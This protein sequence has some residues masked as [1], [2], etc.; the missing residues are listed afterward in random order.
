ME[1]MKEFYKGN[2]S[3]TKVLVSSGA[4]PKMVTDFYIENTG[5]MKSIDINVDDIRVYND[6]VDSGD[7][8]NIKSRLYVDKSSNVKITTRTLSDAKK[9]E[10]I[11]SKYPYDKGV[12]AYFYFGD[13]AVLRYLSTGELA[14]FITTSGTLFQVPEFKNTALLADI[15]RDPDFLQAH[16]IGKYLLI[17]TKNKITSTSKFYTALIDTTDNS[18]I[19]SLKGIKDSA[20]NLENISRDI[21]T[22]WFSQRIDKDNFILAYNNSTSN[23][24]GRFTPY[25]G[26]VS[27]SVVFLINSKLNKIER[28]SNDGSAGGSTTD[29]V[30]EKYLYIPSINSIIYGSNILASGGGRN[31]S[32]INLTTMNIT[33][34][35][36]FNTTSQ[37]TLINTIVGVSADSRYLYM[38]NYNNVFGIFD[39]QNRSVD[40]LD[41]YNV[42]NKVIYKGRIFNN[43]GSKFRTIDGKSIYESTDTSIM[44][45]DQLYHSCGI[46]VKNE[47]KLINH[48][49]I[50]DLDSCKFDTKVNEEGYFKMAVDQPYRID[51]SS[52]PLE[53]DKNLTE[54]IVVNK[55][56]STYCTFKFKGEL[57]LSDI[58]VNL[59]TAIIKGADG[60][61]YILYAVNYY[62]FNIKKVMLDSSSNV[63]VSVDY[64]KNVA[65]STSYI[66][67]SSPVFSTNKATSYSST[68]GGLIYANTTTGTFLFKGNNSSGYPTVYCVCIEGNAVYNDYV[69]TTGYL[70]T[71]ST[72]YTNRLGV[73]ERNNEVFLVEMN[74]TGY[75]CTIH[76]FHPKTPNKVTS[77]ATT[78]LA[79]YKSYY[80][81][82]STPNVLSYI[83]L[84]E[85]G[86]VLHPNHTN[87]NKWIV[88]YNFTSYS[89]V[90]SVSNRTEDDLFEDNTAQNDLVSG[91]VFDKTKYSFIDNSLKVKVDG[92]EFI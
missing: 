28:L 85:D 13:G 38:V 39:T 64:A 57:T 18:M 92:I 31:F 10:V 69:G 21:S 1:K 2:V 74:T 5:D 24:S 77:I 80:V 51:A 17:N 9:V 58:P 60:S 8:I 62:T 42:G 30:A 75:Y 82:A 49:S 79:N 55:Q 89:H 83:L 70:Y 25:S 43:Q 61:Y 3:D 6:T 41:S 27:A 16:V 54:D 45:D 26:I 84:K 20:L 65:F 78:S 29:T 50:L 87:T 37:Q 12:D 33:T 14:V 47:N 15:Q 56:S 4:N 88:P 40:T 52:F 36:T 91:E 19:R 76:R 67:S 23:Q 35:D 44:S 90:K 86:F 7:T 66:H 59:Y 71:Y 53:E 34:I 22:D 73:F 48:N 11:N 46:Y 72:T 63:L 68:Y 32:I 81:A